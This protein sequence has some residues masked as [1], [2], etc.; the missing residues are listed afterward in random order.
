MKLEALPEG[1][2]ALKNVP[3]TEHQ[4]TLR[5]MME[6]EILSLSQEEL[7]AELRAGNAM[8][9]TILSKAGLTPET[10]T[11]D[12]I[13]QWASVDMNILEQ[14]RTKSLSSEEQLRLSALLQG[15]IGVQGTSFFNGDA[16]ESISTPKFSVSPSVRDALQM[17]VCLEDHDSADR[18]W[19]SMRVEMLKYAIHNSS[20]HGAELIK[21]L[22]KRGF[23]KIVENAERKSEDYIFFP[24]QEKHQP[25]PEADGTLLDRTDPLYLLG[26]KA[27]SISARARIGWRGRLAPWPKGAGAGRAG[28]ACRWPAAPPQLRADRGGG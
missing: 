1:E 8:A 12:L 3:D 9:T 5:Q 2:S 14:I 21:A 16:H 24:H 23:Q 28:A 15:A 20:D 13:A 6:G 10:Y 25:V 7:Q 18:T 27:L 4:V 19:D 26:R 11:A 22:Q 17:R